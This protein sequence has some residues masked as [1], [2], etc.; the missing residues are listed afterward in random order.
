MR[1]S[2]RLASGFTP[3]LIALA[4]LLTP[5]AAFGFCRTKACSDGSSDPKLHCTR[6]DRG[7][8]VSDRPLFWPTSCVS[9]TVQED[10]SPLRELDAPTTR[11][12][13]AEAFDAWLSADCGSGQTPSVQVKDDGLVECHRVEYNSDRPNAHVFMYR[14]DA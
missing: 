12:I 7:C 4:G 5:D 10:G 13:V 14:D 8:L 2:P 11:T 1:S 9:F 3:L 6:D